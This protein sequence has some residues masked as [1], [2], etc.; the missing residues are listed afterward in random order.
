MNT[1]L[2]DPSISLRRAPWN[3]RPQRQAHANAAGPTQYLE[4]IGCSVLSCRPAYDR[5]SLASLHALRSLKLDCSANVRERVFTRGD[6]PDLTPER[7]QQPWRATAWG[8]LA[9]GHVHVRQPEDTLCSLGSG[10]GHSVHRGGAGEPLV[11]IHGFFCSGEYRELDLRAELPR[12]E[13]PTLVLAGDS[14]PMIPAE[15]SLELAGGLGKAQRVETHV[16]A[17]A[18]HVLTG[19]SRRSINGCYGASWPRLLIDPVRVIGRVES[20][21]DP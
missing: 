18:G 12:I 8:E 6:E 20:H 3:R 14:D 7:W 9:D 10:S 15:R 5:G 19:T 4:D 11:L 1:G 16:I 2:D 21:V 13:L 17:E